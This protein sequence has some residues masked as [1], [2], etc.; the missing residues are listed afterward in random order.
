MNFITATIKVTEHT[1]VVKAYGLD[2]LTASAEIT[3]SSG[4]GATKL[5]LLNYN[6]GEKGEVFKALPIGK[7][8]LITGQIIFP[9]D[10]NAVMDVIVRT[11]EP[12]VAND[13]YVNQVVLA[14]AFFGKG[15]I[16]TQ[17][18]S[19]VS[20][21]IGVKNDNQDQASWLRLEIAPTLFDKLE[22]RRKTGR[23]LTALGYLREY[24]S[25]GSEG[26]YRAL[27]CADFTTDYE[28]PREG[29]SQSASAAGYAETEPAPDFAT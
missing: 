13:M 19:N 10:K 25:E 24:R 16:K 28:G 29:R 14:S 6:G 2:Y 27:V 20:L 3:G 4:S 23:K 15:E 18:N 26:A 17:S 12:S 21:S 1:G 11:I 7:T 9:D 5:R 22:A 8:T